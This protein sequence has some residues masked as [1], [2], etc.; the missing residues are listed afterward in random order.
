MEE[1]QLES[2]STEN[3]VTY[4]SLSLSLKLIFLCT[5]RQREREH[6]R[7]RGG[8]CAEI[9]VELRQTGLE[10]PALPLVNY[11]ITGKLNQLLGLLQWLNEICV[12]S[13]VDKW[14]LWISAYLL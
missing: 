12:W 9:R 7:L 1:H 11:G 3:E 14:E 10:V 2:L 13:K 6:P 8:G 5:L 4:K